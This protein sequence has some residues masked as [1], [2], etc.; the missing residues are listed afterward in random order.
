VLNLSSNANCLCR[1]CQ[2]ARLAY[3]RRA[4]RERFAATDGSHAALADVA[5]SSRYVVLAWQRHCGS[6]HAAIA[7]ETARVWLRA[8]AREH[9]EALC[10]GR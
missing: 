1:D 8:I 2:A 4:A 6:G 10:S 5:A 7:A 9:L 3:A